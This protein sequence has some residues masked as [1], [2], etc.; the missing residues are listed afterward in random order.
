VSIGIL[1]AWLLNM[2]GWNPDREHNEKEK[3]MAAA[4]YTAS[5]AG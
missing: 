2:P 5:C 3:R 4:L 1:A